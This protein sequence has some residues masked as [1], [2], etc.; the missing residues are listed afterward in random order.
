MGHQRAANILF[1][2]ESSRQL[3]SFIVLQVVTIG[4]VVLRLPLISTNS[5]AEVLVS[6][7][8]WSGILPI[9][10]IIFQGR[11]NRA[12]LATLK[13][14]SKKKYLGSKPKFWVGFIFTVFLL[15]TP[16][17]INLPEWA[18]GLA[19]L[20]TFLVATL[21]SR[22]Y[23]HAFGVAQGLGKSPLVNFVLV[24]SSLASLG[25]TWIAYYHLGLATTNAV[26]Q[27][28]FLLDMSLLVSATGPIFSYYLVRRL[29]IKVATKPF[30]LA[31]SIK[32][33]RVDAI[34]FFFA[35]PPILFTALDLS[36][37]ALFSDNFQIL[38]YGF[39]SK[40]AILA[41]FLPAALY[42][43][44]SNKL[45]GNQVTDLKQELKP[46]ALL[47]LANLPFI[48][49]FIL[50]GSFFADFLSSG[51]TVH[52]LWLLLAFSLVSILQPLW[53]VIQSHLSSEEHVRELIAKRIL[54]IVVPVSII[55]TGSGAFTLGATGV[56]AA[57][58]VSYLTAIGVVMPNYLK[59]F[60]VQL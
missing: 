41:S 29:C 50:L 59:R 21:I 19:G 46:V 36:F 56:V 43:P 15:A 53:I 39:Y 6:F 34:E 47:T 27:L 35:M 49:T 60:S 24:G 58:F 54:L 22:A 8:F 25:I 26:T 18:F 10:Q 4:T 40:C 16:L 45:T 2:K 33:I 9:S 5:S 57:T 44:L 14:Y 23:S 7:L 38:Q 11:V 55:S 13:S 48:L 42:L 3:L 37:L 1:G 52:S 20:P 17:A 12:R 30:S 28:S 31:N 32:N 51:L